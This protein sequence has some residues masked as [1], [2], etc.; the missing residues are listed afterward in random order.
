MCCAEAACWSPVAG[1]YAVVWTTGNSL[2]PAHAVCCWTL[3]QAL[4]FIT[5]IHTCQL[6]HVV[7]LS[8]KHTCGN[9]LLLGRW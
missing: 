4:S 7:P 1:V 8:P 2:S 3:R 9:W 5:F 6:L